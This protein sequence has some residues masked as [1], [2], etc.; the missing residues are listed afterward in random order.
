MAEENRIT[1]YKGFDKDLCCSG[2]QYEVGKEYEHLGEVKCY[3]SGFHACI[4]PFDVLNYY[5]AYGG[6]RFC[7]VE[8]Y[9]V[10]DA[11]NDLYST[12]HASSK[13]A[14]KEEIGIWG[15]CREALALLTNMGRLSV[16]VPYANGRT[17]NTLQYANQKITSYDNKTVF[18]SDI[19]SATITSS[20]FG[21]NIGST[22]MFANIASTGSASIGSTGKYARIYSRGGYG[23]IVSSGIGATISSHGQCSVI[24]SMGAKSSITSTGD[25]AM[26]LSSG[27]SST[28]HSTCCQSK[29]ESTGEDSIIVCLGKESMVKAKKGSWITLAEWEKDSA[30]PINV[31]T[32]YVDNDRIK[33]DTWYTLIDGKFCV[34]EE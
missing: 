33:A 10:I 5:Y 1:A 18:F 26:I 31:K 25:R 28:I 2:F 27:D 34:V 17:I 30:L 24:C 16:L 29:I 15:L 23:G 13:I 9:G 20:G 4:N 8:Q 11:R 14:I 6:N 12:E 7:K 19:N 21:V 32:K 22:A 3:T